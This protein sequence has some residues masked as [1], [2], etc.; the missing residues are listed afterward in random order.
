[1][2]GTRF[3]S[4]LTSFI[5]GKRRFPSDPAPVLL[6]LAGFVG[7][8]KFLNPAWEKILGYPAQ[9]LLDRPLRE[10][11]QQHGQ[12]AATLVDR[13]LTEDSFDPMEFGLRCQGIRSTRRSS[14]R[15]MTSPTKRAG[16]SPRYNDPMEDRKELTLRF[17]PAKEVA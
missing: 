3:L 1:M 7:K 5:R 15:G 2:S 13:L 17:E 12:A 6:G 10:L 14:S 4:R 9:E 11:M 16:R 8:L